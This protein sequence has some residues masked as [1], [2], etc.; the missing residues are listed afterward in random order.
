M[1]PKSP[2]ISLED[3]LTLAGVVAG[4]TA[5]IALAF[6]TIAALL[7]AAFVILKVL[8]VIT[9]GWLWVVSPV[10]VLIS[11]PIG[12]GLLLAVCGGIANFSILWYQ[13]AKKLLK[14]FRAKH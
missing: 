6:S 3:I 2:Y 9:F 7:T 11:I 12:I 14:I 5:I 4:G 8:G 1:K 10:W 13:N